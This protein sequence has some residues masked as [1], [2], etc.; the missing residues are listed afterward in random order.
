MKRLA[1]IGNPVAHSRSP[2]IHA[3]FAAQAG[4]DILYERL[5]APVGDFAR[6]ARAFLDDGG[7]GFNITVPFKHEAWALAQSRSDAAD[8]SET[9]NTIKV[10]RDGSLFGDNTDGT[11]LVGDLESNLR[12]PIDG[13]KVLV[14]GAGGAVAAVLP[15]LLARRPARLD[16]YN[17]THERAARLASRYPARVRA[18]ET[19]ADA[20]PYDLV[21]SGSSAGLSGSSPVLSP[22]IVG[23]RTRCYDMIYSATTTPFNAWA[24][25]SGAAVTSDG[26]GMLVMQAASAFS[27]WF[28]FEPDTAPVIAL[29]R[30]SI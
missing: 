1:V 21:V 19:L 13:A 29:L 3:A 11:G 15:A 18:L 6:V 28:E 10:L 8:A 27:L 12:W 5:L 4:I 25:E 23:P 16:L 22:A 30:R 2:E 24:M 14:I 7:C 20:G 9:V 17:R 26:L